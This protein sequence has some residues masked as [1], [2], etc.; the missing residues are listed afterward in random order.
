[1]KK[2]IILGMLS[3]SILSVNA[4]ELPKT[5]PMAVVT[6]AVG[7]NNIKIE[8]SRPGVKG[9][10]IFG[11]LVPFDKVWRLGANAPTKLT[12]DKSIT[13]GGEELKA[14]T[15]AIFA[16]P[17]E[18]EW[19]I[20]INTDVEQ[21]GAG[22]YDEKKNVATVV[23]KPLDSDFTESLSVT[24]QDVT[25]TGGNIVIAWAKVKVNVPFTVDT[26]KA[27]EEN[28]KA[29][30]KEG[31]D[32]EKVYAN[33]AGYYRDAKGDLKTAIKYADKSIKVKEYYGNL[34]LKARIL[35]ESGDKKEAIV[36]AN[37]AL[38]SAKKAEAKGY[39]SF[40]EETL[41]RWNK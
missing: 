9:R 21:W 13:I 24:V 19:K 15:Y 3:L 30:I 2:S 41:V 28:I 17:S 39:V 26:D 10:E 22:D 27:A 5:S 32:L 35:E 14:G 33:A 18:N 6:Q 29:A 40:I 20:V 25:A 31:K 36:Y 11:D 38:E 12:T 34:F 23:V 8:Y 4:Q 1:M 37:K 16:I 7:L